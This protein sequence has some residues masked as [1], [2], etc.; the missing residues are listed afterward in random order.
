MGGDNCHSQPE[1]R[2]WRGVMLSLIFGLR[3]G[4]L[5]D[6]FSLWVVFF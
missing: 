2:L 1:R 6:Y 3:W 4:H 5:E